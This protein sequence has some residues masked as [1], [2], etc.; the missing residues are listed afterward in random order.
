MNT[1]SKLSIKGANQN[2]IVFDDDRPKVSTELIM[3]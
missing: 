1:N 2:R 3:K